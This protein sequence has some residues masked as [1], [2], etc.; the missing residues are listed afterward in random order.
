MWGIIATWRMA[1]EGIDEAVVIL[2][3]Q[4]DS[5]DALEIAIKNVENNP[6]YKSVGYGGLPNQEQVVELDASF[7]DGNTLDIGA[8]GGL[9][10]FANPI[11]IARAL[12]Q[13]YYNNFLVGEGAE[14]YASSHGFE[15]KNMLTKRAKK[16]YEKRKKATLDQGLSPYS[17]HDT[18][19]MVTLDMQCKMCAGTSTSGLFMKRPGRV[20]DSP[21]PGSGYYVDSR[22]GGACATGLGEDVMKGCA[23]Y[24]IV[25]LMKEGLSPQEA[26]EKVVNDLE[27]T[28][29]ERKGV[30]GDLS[31]VAMD[32][33]GRWGVATNIP[34]FSFVVATEMT[35]TTVY[36]SK[37]VDGHCIHTP[38][39]Q[40]WLEA[41]EKRIREPL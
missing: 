38:A 11:S 3:Q 39:S 26:C 30:V 1:K 34:E 24:E 17:G 18:V 31:F 10:D 32:H 14:K 4:G 5:G 9:R 15:R 41:Y 25:R 6:F 36:L 12:S 21:I 28:L 7:M 35:P 8:V 37:R 16:H 27:K 23:T 29:L 13:E 22:I 33:L 2:K 20:G 40:S 19:G